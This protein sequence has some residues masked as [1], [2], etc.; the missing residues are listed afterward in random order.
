MKPKRLTR[1]ERKEQTRERLLNAARDV[2]STKG[3]ISS[4][5]EDIA[6]AA[7]YTR[8][9]FYSNFEDKTDLLLELLRRDHD[10][11]EVEAQRIF[12]R[13]KSREEMI[14]A[15]LDR[16][17][18]S[19]DKPKPHLL[20]ME[21]KLHSARDDHFRTKFSTL[22]RKQQQEMAAYVSSMAEC[23]GTKLPL[24]AELLALGLVALREGL[25]SWRAAD[26][27]NLPD[28]R[29]EAVLTRFLAFALSGSDARL[30]DAALWDDAV[31]RRIR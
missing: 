1:E 6:A 12:D 25:Q 27:C 10:E 28:Q 31:A 24:P 4:S 17:R 15:S 14:A 22:L 29:V 16:F 30:A 18:L 19:N 9:A 20:W 3:F 11:V 5:V 8:G 21:A 7:G 23:T 2:F 13:C 26:S